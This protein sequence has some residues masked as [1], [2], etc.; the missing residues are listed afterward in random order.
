MVG[1]GSDK[2][3]NFMEPTVVSGVKLDDPL[4]KV[5]DDQENTNTKKTQRQRK[6][7]DKDEIRRLTIETTTVS[8]VKLD[9]PFKKELEDKL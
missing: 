6:L 1:G 2:K 3:T 4:M 7:E 9:A 8:G 5:L